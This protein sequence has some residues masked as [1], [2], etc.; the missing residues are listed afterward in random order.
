VTDDTIAKAWHSYLSLS[1]WLV[2]APLRP[3]QVRAV[4]FAGVYWLMQL[5]KHMRANPE[6]AGAISAALDA[7][8]RDYCAA[9]ETAIRMQE[10]GS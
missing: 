10:E 3:E 1:P 7:E 8:I 5:S 2:G 9:V 4:F 6:K